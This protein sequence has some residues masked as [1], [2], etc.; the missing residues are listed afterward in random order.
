MS[1]NHEH[2]VSS[3]AQ[4]WM[5]G[6]ALI[7]LTVVTVLFARVI[8]LPAPINIIV[9][10]CIAGVKATLVAAF[11]MN[12]YWDSKF[13]TLLL[14]GALAFFILMV[15]ITLLDTLYRVEVIPGF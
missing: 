2:H 1:E 5:V 9:A 11:F 3:T 6:G 4:L 14:L 12:L 13:N 7:L 8:H 15:A 10:L